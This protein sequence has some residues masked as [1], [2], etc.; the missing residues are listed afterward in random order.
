[1]NQPLP[2]PEQFVARL[3]PSHC[4][5]ADPPFLPAC[6]PKHPA[7]HVPATRPAI[8]PGRVEPSS[9]LRV[10]SPSI[11][12]VVTCGSAR[13]HQRQ[14]EWPLRMLPDRHY[15]RGC[16]HLCRR[17]CWVCRR[18]LFG[19]PLW[20]PAGSCVPAALPWI[21]CPSCTASCSAAAHA[22]PAQQ[23]RRPRHLQR[24]WTAAVAAAAEQP[25]ATPVLLL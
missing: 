19:C 3:H 25:A 4:P 24:R 6:T 5:A 14:Q 16:C 17:C 15:L 1:M 11:F 20:P 13:L 8:D 9:P 22:A 7:A 23:R 12:A 18:L 10:F 21:A 2:L